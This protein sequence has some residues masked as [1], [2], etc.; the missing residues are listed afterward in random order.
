MYPFPLT[1]IAATL[2]P[3]RELM[4]VHLVIEKTYSFTLTR[5]AG[6]PLLRRNGTRCTVVRAARVG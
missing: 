3:K 2:P 5:I 1:R 6:K 4:M